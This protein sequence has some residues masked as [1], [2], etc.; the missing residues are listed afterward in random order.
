MD[1]HENCSC[2]SHYISLN[3]VI[4]AVFSLKKNKCCDDASIQA[5]HI[6]NAPMPLY[7]RLESLF[8]AMLLHS[9]VPIQFQRGTIVPIIKDRKGDM[10]NY[11]GIT[12]APIIS[13]VF[14]HALQIVFQS[15]LTTSAHQFGFKQKS[16]TSLAIHCLKETINYY[17][18]HGSN[19][20]CSFL[21]A[22]KA[23][24]RLVYAGLFIK[25]IKRQVPPTRLNIIVEEGQNGLGDCCPK[26]SREGRCFL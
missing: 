14:E 26:G 16:S 17:M 7:I 21:D 22:S 15:S 8:N 5:E 9:F 24:D 6:F 1:N 13:K 3:N 25:L 20:Y 2:A 19:V 4:D 18:S 12:L 11:R 10:N 23:F